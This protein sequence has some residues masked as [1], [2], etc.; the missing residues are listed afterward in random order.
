MDLLIGFGV[1]SL[2]LAGVDQFN[3]HT[4]QVQYDQFLQRLLK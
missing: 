3:G 4:L 2:Q 1:W